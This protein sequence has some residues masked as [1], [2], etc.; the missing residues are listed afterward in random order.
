[1]KS[2]NYS[3]RPRNSCSRRKNESINW[4]VRSTNIKT[5]KRSFKTRSLP[6]NNS[7]RL[8][9]VML[10]LRK[11]T[12]KLNYRRCSRDWQRLSRTS[13]SQSKTLRIVN[14]NSKMRLIVC[15]VRLKIW[16]NRLSN[17]LLTRAIWSKISKK[18]LRRCKETTAMRSS[19]WNPSIW[20]ARSSWPQP[21]KIK[22]RICTRTTKS[23]SMSSNSNS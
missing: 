17:Y 14:R 16:R 23:S 13:N 12:S 3:R 19:V 5:S 6:S 11:V 21:T 4:W 18:K 9:S 10:R 20:Q 7:L 22:S 2:A 15:A 1:M 8:R